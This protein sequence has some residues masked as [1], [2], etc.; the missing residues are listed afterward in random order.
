MG[1]E[2]MNSSIQISGLSVGTSGPGA[3]V[4]IYCVVVR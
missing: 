4:I 3:T 2:M 1:I